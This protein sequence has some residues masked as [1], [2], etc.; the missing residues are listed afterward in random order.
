M[1]GKSDIF[2]GPSHESLD[3]VTGADVV[4][5]KA[6]TTGTRVLAAVIDSHNGDF[7]GLSPSGY[8][9]GL[10]IVL[11]ATAAMAVAVVLLSVVS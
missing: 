10:L 3:P 1:N 4:A 6:V 9:R 5:E 8:L 11:A 7:P 2:P